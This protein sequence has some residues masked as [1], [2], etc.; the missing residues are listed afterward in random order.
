MS[1]DSLGDQGLVERFHRLIHA[2]PRPPKYKPI[3][4]TEALHYLRRSLEAGI[5]LGLYGF[6]ENDFNAA[7]GIIDVE[8]NIDEV[9]Y[10]LLTHVSIAVGHHVRDATRAAPIYTYVLAVDK[11]M[12]AL[13]DLAS[14][15][16]RGHRFTMELSNE[17]IALSDEPVICLTSLHGLTVGRILDDYGIDVIAILR[18]GQW[19][20]NPGNEE[21]IEANDKV[22][23]RG[24]KDSLND[25]LR[26][27]KR[28]T[29]PAKE[30][31]ALGDIVSSIEML[32]VMN[33]LAHYQLRAQDPVLAE[34]ILELEM[35]MDKLRERNTRT[36]LTRMKNISYEDKFLLLSLVTRIEDVSDALAYII[37]MPATE[38]YR[39]I[40]SSLVE[41]SGDRI[42]IYRSQSHVNLATIIETLDEIGATVLAVQR[43]GEWI[44]VTPYNIERIQLEPGDKILV[45]YERLLE[46]R[47]TKMLN[48]LGLILQPL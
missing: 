5:L 39:E 43:K 25:I 16:I 44:A 9:A 12:D 36:I 4:V 32:L 31:G 17:L 10:Q 40:L 41:A 45:E 27:V 33:E 46:H 15:I 18:D 26:D 3:T 1:R 11:V 19:I 37:L 8:K 48:K 28:P 2:K 13:K 34:E 38:E 22:Y 14:L 35:F 29:L 6:I 42:S 7:M 20:L 30:E 21:K 23:L 47:V 24:V